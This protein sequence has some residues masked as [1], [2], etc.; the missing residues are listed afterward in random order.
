VLELILNFANSSNTQSLVLPDR[1]PGCLL[2]EESSNGLWNWAIKQAFSPSAASTAAPSLASSDGSSESSSRSEIQELREGLVE[3]ANSLIRA[4]ESTDFNIDPERG[5]DVDFDES[6]VTEDESNLRKPTPDEDDG[7]FIKKLKTIAVKAL[8]KKGHESG[9]ESVRV[10]GELCYVR[11]KNEVSEEKFVKKLEDDIISLAK[12]KKLVDKTPFI[13]KTGTTWDGGHCKCCK[14]SDGEPFRFG[15]SKNSDDHIGSRI[16][17]TNAKK[18][19]I[20]SVQGIGRSSIADLNTVVRRTVFMPEKGCGW[21]KSS[22]ELKSLDHVVP[23]L[24]SG[25]K[26][27]VRYNDDTG[28]TRKTGVFT[29]SNIHKGT[30]VD[31]PAGKDRVVVMTMEQSFSQNVA[32]LPAEPRT[33]VAGTED[34]SFYLIPFCLSLPGATSEGFSVVPYTSVVQDNKRA[35]ARA[36]YMSRAGDSGSPAVLFT[37]AQAS[38]E[39]IFKPHEPHYFH[40]GFHGADRILVGTV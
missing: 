18:V 4:R 19:G 13:H 23:S 2:T 30:T 5:D 36:R 21:I 29:V 35:M 9:Y 40:N 14:R 20:E 7:P 27:N 37:A 11:N 22:K 1:D 25:Q 26:L 17:A 32:P 3:L 28:R 10:G 8:T 31:A 24:Q 16:H 15:T 34:S 12:L 38:S 33:L 6:G 39:P